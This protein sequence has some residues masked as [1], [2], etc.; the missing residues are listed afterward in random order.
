MLYRVTEGNTVRWPDGS[1]RAEEGEV[2]ESY[3]DCSAV[4]A[5][6]YASA[7]LHGQHKRCVRV[8]DT[9]TGEVRPVA[10]GPYRDALEK[11]GA[12]VI[13]PTVPSKGGKSKK[14]PT[15]K[16]DEPL[17][18]AKEEELPPAAE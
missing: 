12:V 11:R 4:L 9:Y 5:A 7:V 17:G 18:K 6:T 16:K 2:F 8:P 10:P 1:I 15:T 14:R 3:E 13:E